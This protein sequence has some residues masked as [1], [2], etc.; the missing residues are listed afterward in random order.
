MGMLLQEE[1]VAPVVFIL[2]LSYVLQTFIDFIKENGLTLEKAKAVDISQN[3]G[4][5]MIVW[6][7]SQKLQPK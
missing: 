5:M 1:T 6:H 4:I 3:S 7:F 2:S